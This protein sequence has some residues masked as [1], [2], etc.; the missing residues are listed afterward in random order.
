MVG[1]GGSAIS[2]PMLPLNKPGPGAGSGT[3][4]VDNLEYRGRGREARTRRSRVDT[5]FLI[6]TTTIIIMESASLDSF[7]PRAGACGE[8]WKRQIDELNPEATTMS[9]T[10]P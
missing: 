9:S 4:A 3:G 6:L 8:T 5:D 1:R 10:G 7:T 2:Q